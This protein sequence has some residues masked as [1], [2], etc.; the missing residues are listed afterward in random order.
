MR[1]ILLIAALIAGC[2]QTMISAACAQQQAPA[3]LLS[4]ILCDSRA[5]IEAL[6]QAFDGDAAAALAAVNGA[7]NPPPCAPL[8][9]LAVA[10]EELGR[11]RRGGVTYAVT[12][13]TV[14]AVEDNGLLRPVAP[15]EQYTVFELGRDVDA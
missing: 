15:S 14:L 8:R 13:V 2:G 3:Q 5:Q 11:V 7:R 9:V 6:V 10:G 4:A 12:R 1:K